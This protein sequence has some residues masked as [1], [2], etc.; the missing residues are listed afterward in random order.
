MWLNFPVFDKK[1]KVSYKMF[2]IHFGSLGVER[3]HFHSLAEDGH[4]E[5][6]P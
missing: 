1:K 5:H 3:V 6:Q 2:R 4:G